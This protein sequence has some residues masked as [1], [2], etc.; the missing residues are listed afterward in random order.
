VVQL[1]AIREYYATTGRESA[2]ESLDVSGHLVEF[3]ASHPVLWQKPKNL[4]VIEFL[5]LRCRLAGE[6]ALKSTG[7]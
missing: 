6:M 2:S 7:R 3:F 1:R 5:V 4:E